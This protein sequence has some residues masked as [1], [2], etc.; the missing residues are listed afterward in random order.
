MGGYIF[1]TVILY[2]S[3]VSAELWCPVRFESYLFVLKISGHD[4]IRKLNQL[5]RRDVVDVAVV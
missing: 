1:D 4:T 2:M 3:G 5:N